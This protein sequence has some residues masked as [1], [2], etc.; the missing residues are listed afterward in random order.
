MPVDF[1]EVR[2]NAAAQ[3][4][5]LSEIA[6]FYENLADD[7]IAALEQQGLIT[8]RTAR[9]VVARFAADGSALFPEKAVSVYSLAS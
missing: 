4:V 9:R 5:P 6:I 8:D 2:K 7:E 1:D 3:G